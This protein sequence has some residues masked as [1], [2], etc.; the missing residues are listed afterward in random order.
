MGREEWGGEGLPHLRLWPCKNKKGTSLQGLYISATWSKVYLSQMISKRNKNGEMR[1][2]E[3]PP[4]AGLLE[5]L[6]SLLQM[7]LWLLSANKRHLWDFLTSKCFRV[8]AR[9]K[10]FFV[11]EDS[12]SKLCCAH[13]Q[14]LHTEVTFWASVSLSIKLEATVNPNLCDGELK[15]ALHLL[16][17]FRLSP[18]QLSDTVCAYNDLT[19]LALLLMW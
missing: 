16:P 2:S 11:S 1:K 3:R 4:N 15:T 5:T 12:E 10:G 17:N 8:S 9:G 18:E 13:L 19:T 7:A 14:K 6:W